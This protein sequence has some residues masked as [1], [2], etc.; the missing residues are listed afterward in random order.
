MP[1]EIR[2]PRLG[3]SMDEGVFNGWL[4]KDGDTVKAGD[5]V[6][7]LEGEKAAEDIEATDGGTLSI[8]ENSP[9]PGETVKVGRIIGLLLQEYEPCAGQP[10]NRPPANTPGIAL[11]PSNIVL[12]PVR[13]DPP[14]DSPLS[15]VASSPRARRRAASLGLDLSRLK[16]SGRAGRIIESDVL[17]A[18]ARSGGATVPG[19]E[20][21]SKMRRAIAE[22]T[23]SSFAEIP[24]FYLRL[25]VDVTDLVRLREDMVSALERECGARIT[26]TDFILRAQALALRDF[27]A[28]NAVWRNDGVFTFSDSN[29]GLVVGTSEGLAIPIIRAAQHLSLVDIAGERERLVGAVR[30]GHLNTDPDAVAATSLS[31]LGP[32]R[33][34]EFSAII[35]PCQSSM[36]AVGRAAPRP[37]VIGDRLEVRTTMRLC[38]SVDHRV[39]DGAPAA[40]FLARIAGLLENPRSLVPTRLANRAG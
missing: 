5:P 2:I 31:N 8:S 40:D 26:L 10:A 4:K 32:A 28:A 36:L 7:N 11:D 22:R 38:L 20:K 25:E 23:A 9:K 18:A 37:Y 6:F 39:L 34:D 24:H 27:P 14:L 21:V 19:S 35:A 33:V 29:V 15:T 3:W 12:A 17:K 13:Q 16:G 30:N 1:I